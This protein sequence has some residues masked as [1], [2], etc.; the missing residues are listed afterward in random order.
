MSEDRKTYKGTYTSQ[1]IDPTGNSVPEFS[2]EGDVLATRFEV[3][4]PVGAPQV[5][6]KALAVNSLSSGGIARRRSC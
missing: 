1:F 4:G 2:A 5:M 6:G 3:D